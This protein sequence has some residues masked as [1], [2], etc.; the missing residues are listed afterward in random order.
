MDAGLSMDLIMSTKSS[1]VFITGSD[2]NT[3]WLDNW[4]K[5]NFYKHNPNAELV[6]YDFDKYFNENQ[7]WFK[8]PAAMLEASMTFDSVCWIDNDIE[9]RSNIERIFDFIE[10]NKL[11]MAED[12]PWS[13]RRGE[14]WHNSGVVGF[15]GT[16]KI[17]REWAS[18]VQ[19]VDQRPNPMYGDQDVLHELVRGDMKRFIH[20]TDL[21]RNYNT[22]RL[23]LI[24]NTA[25][26]T[27]RMMHWTGAKGK[28]EI[29]RQMNE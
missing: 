11:L 22:L 18:A 5:S 13:T 29:K 9:I 2:S 15:Q 7:R 4:F 28:E 25:P 1:K 17:L 3:R 12:R 16:P 10:P 21:P 27:I 24:D 6:V 14:K 26:P 19:T 8:K 20:I 23:D